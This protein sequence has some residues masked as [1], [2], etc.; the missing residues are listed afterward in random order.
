MQTTGRVDGEEG[1]AKSEGEAEAEAQ[2]EV[3]V[4]AQAQAQAQAQTQAQAQAQEGQAQGGAQSRSA[5]YDGGPPR[6][7]RWRHAR[8]ARREPH[9]EERGPEGSR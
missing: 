6:F 8:R 7:I 1:I 2:A 9:P 3:E 4:Q 5:H